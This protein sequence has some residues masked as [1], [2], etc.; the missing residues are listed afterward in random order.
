MFSFYY[1]MEYEIFYKLNSVKG[2]KYWDFFP[3]LIIVGL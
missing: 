2:D 3:I 1:Y